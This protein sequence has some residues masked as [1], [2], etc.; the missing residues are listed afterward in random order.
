M[1]LRCRSTVRW[2]SESS[3]AMAA[4]VLPAETSRSTCSSRRVSPCRAGPTARRRQRIEP[5]EVG[6]RAEVL[7][8]HTRRGEFQLGPV[9][10]GERPARA[11]DQAPD[12]RGLVRRPDGLPDLE[13]AA[14]GGK[15]GRCL[16]LRQQHRAA[17]L[18]GDR[19]GH[20]TSNAAATCSNSPQARSAPSMSPAASAIS[21]CAGS[22]R[23]RQSGSAVAPSTRRIAAAAAAA[24]PCASRSSAR[25]GCGSQPKP[26]ARR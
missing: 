1:L 7:E 25:P 19:L 13:R 24:A 6:H 9:V 22:N 14:Q 17:G 21:I 16:S 8:D 3:A 5:G 11:A 26:L 2:L 23:A 12:A 10:I 15:R 4:L 20:A 18:G